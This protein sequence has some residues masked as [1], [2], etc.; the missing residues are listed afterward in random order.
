MPDGSIDVMPDDDYYAETVP[1]EVAQDMALLVLRRTG[2]LHI[3]AMA[4]VLHIMEK[5][6]L[7]L[8]GNQI[9]CLAETLEERWK[10]D[11]AEVPTKPR[12]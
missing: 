1:W 10:L 2:Q 8:T 12:S 7:E 4:A 11:S 6:R 3:L 9:Q 5:E